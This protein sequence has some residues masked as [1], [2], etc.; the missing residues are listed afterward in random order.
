MLAIFVPQLTN[1][2]RYVFDTVFKEDLG[3]DYEV[4]TDKANFQVVDG[5]KLSYDYQPLDGIQIRS[6]RGQISHK[7]WSR[8]WLEQIEAHCSEQVVEQG[9][10]IARKNQVLDVKISG[11]KLTS[12]IQENRRNRFHIEV[13]LELKDEETWNSIIDECQDNALIMSHLFSAQLAEEFITLC[14]K[15]KLD[16]FVDISKNFQCD[17]TFENEQFCPHLISLVCVIA[18]Q[19]DL[20]P[21]IMFAMNGINEDS[22]MNK[23]KAKWGIAINRPTSNH[24]IPQL[25]DLLTTFYKSPNQLPEDSSYF[26]VKNMD[27]LSCLGFPP[28][29]PAGENNIGDVLNNLYRNGKTDS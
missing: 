8:Q 4:Y 6:R 7:W 1:R 23:V 19:M 26:E 13:D 16:F 3:I 28:F 11:N 29:F 9:R 21:F 10:R 17:C 18:E 12:T 27:V 22:F 2:V 25:E 20:S 14:Q 5:N 24:D 15:H